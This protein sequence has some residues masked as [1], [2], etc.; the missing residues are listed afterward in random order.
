MRRREYLQLSVAALAGL[1][2]CSSLPTSGPVEAVGPATTARQTTGVE[3]APQPPPQGGSPEIILAGFLAAMSSPGGEYRAARQYLTPGAQKLWNPNASTTIYEA[4]NNKPITTDSSA[5]LN[6]P[7]FGTLDAAGRFVPSSQK[8]V[9]DFGMQRSLGQWRISRPPTGVLIARYIFERY[10][11]PL[12]LY[13]L[14]A[15]GRRLVPDRIHRHTDAMNPTDTV[16]ALLGGPASWLAPAVTNAIPPDTRL[17]VNAVALREGIAEISLTEQISSLPERRRTQLAAQLVAT[18][19]QFPQMEG[20]RVLNNGQP[21]QVPG[22]ASNGVVERDVLVPFEMLDEREEEPVHAVVNDRIGVLDPRASGGF[23][24]L[25]GIF[26]K[27]GWGDAPGGFAVQRN[28]DLVAVVNKAG[29]KL[30]TAASTAENA[31]LVHVGSNLLRPQVVDDG[32]VWTVGTRQGASELVMVDTLGRT[33]TV[34][35]SIPSGHRVRA[36]RIAP[37]RT[38]LALALDDGKHQVLGMMRIRG[39][40]PLLVDGWRPLALTSTSGRL[41]SLRDVG[42]AEP[43]TMV[44]IAGPEG[45]DYLNIYRVQSDASQV[46][47]LG[48]ASSGATPVSLA[49]FPRRSGTTAAYLNDAGECLRF[50][51]SYRWQP[52]QGQVT[53]IT[54]PG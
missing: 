49:V 41:G 22:A 40:G 10:Y 16:Q 44:V 26:G 32:S 21:W 34:P 11:Q 43:G 29:N 31:A 13:F 7:I 1:A 5:S 15:D 6:V 45:D 23:L 3:I 17:S 20:V 46:E 28:S 18:L 8:L 27:G 50:E 48:P 47:N 12:S 39:T 24:A 35:L 25:E 14:S 19:A 54:L 30:F 9:H 52:M 37:D 38:R 33:H 2:G 42:W 36:F 51:G 4:E 53:Q